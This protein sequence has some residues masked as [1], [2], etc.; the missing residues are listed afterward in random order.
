MI[1]VIII[2]CYIYYNLLHNKLVTALSIK[3]AADV[4]AK[5][6]SISLAFILTAEQV[7]LKMVNDKMAE[8]IPP[9]VDHN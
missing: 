8:T 9:F 3:S 5:L 6:D 2:T 1:I 4:S 7:E